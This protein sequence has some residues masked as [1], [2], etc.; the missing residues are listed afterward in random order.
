MAVLHAVAVTLSYFPKITAA[1]IVEDCVVGEVN[2]LML[3]II[4]FLQVNLDWQKNP[5]TKVER[6]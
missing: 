4:N 1:P 2:F 3:W 6:K 5:K